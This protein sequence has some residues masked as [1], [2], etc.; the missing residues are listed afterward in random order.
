MTDKNPAIFLFCALACEARPLLEAWKL[1]KQSTSSPFALYADEQRVVVVSGIGKAAMAG[2]VGHTMASYPSPRLPILLNFGIAGHASQSR[3]SMFLANKIVDSESGKS[4]FPQLP[5]PAPCARSA[6]ISYP[7][8][9][10]D[11]AVADSLYDMEASGFY[12]MA[13]RFSCCEMSHS[14]KIVSD[15]HSH[16]VPGFGEAEVMQ[17]VRDG[18]ST[19]EQVLDSLQRL[20]QTL[21]FFDDKHYQEILGELH[22][23]ASNGAR[24][25]AL[26]QRWSVLFAGDGLDLPWR[27]TGVRSG[28]ELL[29]WLERELQIAE[30]GFEL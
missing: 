22:F 13:M 7:K 29:V 27:Q 5:V 3:G 16:P 19:L 30:G 15:N 14:L 20:R 28:K 1:R 9:V 23:S 18:L 11:Y 4:F 8:P 17:W 10:T 6:L 26:L 25:K 21:V 12:E 24:L 2:A